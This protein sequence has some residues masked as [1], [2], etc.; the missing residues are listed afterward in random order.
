LID[1]GVAKTLKKADFEKMT[2]GVRGTEKYS[3]PEL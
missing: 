1:F 2:T 3:A